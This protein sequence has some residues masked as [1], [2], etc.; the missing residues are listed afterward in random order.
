MSD[1]AP[2]LYGLIVFLV[3]V[4]LFL[5]SRLSQVQAHIRTLRKTLLKLEGERSE[6]AEDDPQDPMGAGD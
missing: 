6:D 4:V 3:I 5:I 2:V 1:A